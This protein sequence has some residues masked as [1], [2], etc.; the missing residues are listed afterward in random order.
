[1]Q[2]SPW[3]IAAWWLKTLFVVIAVLVL[4]PLDSFLR[5]MALPVELVAFL[6]VVVS[7]VAIVVGARVFRVRGE[8]NEPRPW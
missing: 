3:R 4:W 6:S 5:W 1:V 7:L 8:S 2:R